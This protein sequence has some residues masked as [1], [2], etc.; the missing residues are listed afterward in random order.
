MIQ[1][2][3][4]CCSN[5][6]KDKG[7]RNPQAKVAKGLKQFEKNANGLVKAFL[8]DSGAIALPDMST[9]S[10]VKQFIDAVENNST[11]EQIREMMSAN[12]A[13]TFFVAPCP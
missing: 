13:K 9:E 1:C 11:M 3:Q 7:K 4:T 10:D 6:A 2:H 8:K 5:K 12:K